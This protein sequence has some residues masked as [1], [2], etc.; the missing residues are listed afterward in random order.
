MKPRENLKSVFHQIKKSLQKTVIGSTNEPDIAKNVLKILFCKIFDE[1]YQSENG[2]AEFYANI[3]KSQESS[4]KIRVIFTKVKKKFEDVFDKTEEIKLDDE[5]IVFVV[6][7]LQWISLKNSG[8]DAVADAFEVFIGTA[9]KGE[10]GQFFTPR[11]VVRFVI[12][13]LDVDETQKIIDPACGTGG[14][15]VESLRY[16]WKKMDENFSQ[17]K[18][19]KEEIEREKIA[20]ARKNI[21]GCDKDSFLAQACKA[22]MCILG[23]GSANIW[24]DDSLIKFTDNWKEKYE[25]VATNPPFGKT[26]AVED[27]KI[28]KNFTFWRKEKDKV[29]ADAAAAA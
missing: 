6:Q 20:V 27:E 21:F 16:I 22:Y 12:N 13:F 5:S 9:L 25:I 10:H 14:F 11:N 24:N 29:A 19:E 8:R 17:K 1:R 26:I 4:E 7:K 3:D 2:F 28:L 18:W 23:D 15:V